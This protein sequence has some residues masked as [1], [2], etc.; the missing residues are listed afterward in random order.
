VGSRLLFFVCVSLAGLVLGTAHVHALPQQALC[1]SGYVDAVIDGEHKCL[2]AGEFCS[3]SAES[4][5]EHYGFT[6]VDGR[7]ESST[8]GQTTTAAPAA[9]GGVY[10]P[11]RRTKTAG[12]RARGALPDRACTPGAVFAFATTREICVPGYSSSVRNV[13]A[14]EKRAAYAEY[15]I[16]AHRRG[17]YEVDHLISLELGGSNAIANLWP[18]AAAPRPGFHQKDAVENFLHGQVCSGAMT[19]AAA[20][21]IIAV[22]WLVEYRKLRG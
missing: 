17:Q 4:Q 7:L 2:H 13:P 22:N 11:P 9:T 5:Y 21:R 8:G 20:Q 1:S 10:A 12:C 15:G 18:E 14:S 16:A 6:C 19:L 3:P